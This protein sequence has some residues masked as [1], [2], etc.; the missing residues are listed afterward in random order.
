MS[1]TASVL[2][3]STRR[4]RPSA[5]MFSERMRILLETQREITGRCNQKFIGRETEMLAEQYDAE[6]GLLTGRTRSCRNVAVTGSPSA[7]GQFV[8][9]RITGAKSWALTGEPL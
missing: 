3:S 7:V 9:V 6:K 8:P 5:T 1:I 2:S 4:P